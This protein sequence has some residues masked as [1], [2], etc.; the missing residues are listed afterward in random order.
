MVQKWWPLLADLI[1]LVGLTGGSGWIYTKQQQANQARLA[2]LAGTLSE[3]INVTNGTVKMLEESV[4][5]L[6]SA[7]VAA[8]PTNTPAKVVADQAAAH[9]AVGSTASSTANSTA[10]SAPAPRSN[11]I[12]INTASVEELDS[13]PGIGAAYAAR[14]VAARPFKSVD[15]LSNVKG[16]GEKTVEKLRSQVTV[17]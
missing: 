11:L 7:P 12:N 8:A 5:A 2:G 15:E 1:I 14:I 17:E 10:S 4:L 3:Q 9:S 16:V 6:K 13:L